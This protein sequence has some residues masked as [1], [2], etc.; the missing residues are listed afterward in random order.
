MESAPFSTG[1]LQLFLAA[2]WIFLSGG[3]VIAPY[4]I[5]FLIWHFFKMHKTLPKSIRLRNY[6]SHFQRNGHYFAFKKRY[7]NGTSKSSRVRQSARRQNYKIKQKSHL[8]NVPDLLWNITMCEC[9][10]LEDCQSNF[11]MTRCNRTMTP[12]LVTLDVNCKTNY[13][14]VHFHEV[15]PDTYQMMLQFI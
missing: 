11:F 6:K 2:A 3:D 5:W 15:Q 9:K 12:N 13:I 4:L 1:W 7:Q 8:E 14:K 10:N